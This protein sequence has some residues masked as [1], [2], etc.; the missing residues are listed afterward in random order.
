MPGAVDVGDDDRGLIADPDRVLRGFVDQ[1]LDPVSDRDDEAERDQLGDLPPSIW[2]TTMLSAKVGKG[3]GCVA[4]RESL[5]SPFH[6]SNWR[7][8][9]D[10]RWPT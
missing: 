10:T 2:P 6:V 7:N 5:A 1:S 9:H 8:S 3:S 4:R